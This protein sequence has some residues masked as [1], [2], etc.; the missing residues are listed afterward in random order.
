MRITLSKIVLA[1]PEKVWEGFNRELF[2][3]L[4]PIFPRLK[5]LRFD[6]CQSGDRVELELD[7]LLFRQ[8]WVSE[9]TEQGASQEDIF[10]ID[11]GRQL[12]FFLKSWRHRHRLI[13]VPQGT[14]I[15]DDI[16][17]RSPWGL[18]GDT[19]LTPGLWLQFRQRHPIYSATFDSPRKPAP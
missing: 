7:F 11:E 15:V 9:I 10:F 3:K 13:R 16:E 1:S 2:E 14:Q 8:R 17:F 19:L 6:G 5:L 4:A 18:L 12:P